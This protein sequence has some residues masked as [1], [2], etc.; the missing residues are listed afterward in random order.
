M[1][2]QIRFVEEGHKCFAHAFHPVKSLADRLNET[3]KAKQVKPT[4]VVRFLNLPSP[5]LC[6]SRQNSGSS[7][8]D[9]SYGK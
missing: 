4:A 1:R 6:T 3:G 5:E 7:S 8:Y 2:L 9:I